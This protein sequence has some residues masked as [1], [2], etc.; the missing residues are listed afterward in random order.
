MAA[1]A[2]RA[3]MYQ[4]GISSAALTNVATGDQD[5]ALEAASRQIDAYLKRSGVELTEWD[6]AITRATCVLAAYDLMIVRGL[7]PSRGSDEFM[8]RYAKTIS[9]L[10]K[11]AQSKLP[12]PTV[13]A[14][15][16]D[17]P[18]GWEVDSRGWDAE[19]GIP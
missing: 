9:W 16:S 12:Q 13:T 18:L 15:S 10:E 1:Y 19:D 7:D 14:D 3:E 11:I 8:L 4:H 6:S 17:A 5:A 2:T